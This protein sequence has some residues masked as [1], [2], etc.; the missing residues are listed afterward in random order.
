M[1]DGQIIGLKTLADVVEALIGVYFLQ[2]DMNSAL[3]AMKWLQVPIPFPANVPGAILAD[4]E[5]KM[6]S[7]NPFSD[8]EIAT[9]ERKVG[10]QFRCKSILL[11]AFDYGDEKTYN[12]AGAARGSFEFQRLEFLGEFPF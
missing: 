4:A 5:E 8:Y 12:E 9:L 3:K 7:R 10:Y 6:Q 1:Q 2:V 11:S